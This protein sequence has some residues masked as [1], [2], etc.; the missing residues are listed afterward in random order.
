M[1]QVVQN[2]QM[3]AGALMW[4]PAGKPGRAPS[5]SPACRDMSLVT[6]SCRLPAALRL[7]DVPYYSF[8]RRSTCARP[9]A[10]IFKLKSNS[11]IKLVWCGHVQLNAAYFRYFP[12]TAPTLPGNP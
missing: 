1:L 4:A 7:A 11:F 6:S 9:P 2:A 3:W 5:R 10:T 8:G 12:L